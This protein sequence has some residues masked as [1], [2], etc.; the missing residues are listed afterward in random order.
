[1]VGN[2]VAFFYPGESYSE[3]PPDARQ[4]VDKVSGDNYHQYKVVSESNS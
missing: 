4:S 1:M 2:A 3:A